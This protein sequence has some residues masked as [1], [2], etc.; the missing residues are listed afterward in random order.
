VHKEVQLSEGGK[1]L[2]LAVCQVLTV[3]WCEEGDPEHDITGWTL[4]N[5]TETMEISQACTFISAPP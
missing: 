5:T 3:L 1:T 2:K 4:E